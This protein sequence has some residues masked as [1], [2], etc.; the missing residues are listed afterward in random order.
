MDQTRRMGQH[1]ERAYL[2]NAPRFS[3]YRNGRD[4]YPSN[5]LDRTLKDGPAYLFGAAL[6]RSGTD[7]PTSLRMPK[8]DGLPLY[9]SGTHIPQSAFHIPHFIYPG[10]G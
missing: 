8:S 4:G 9:N 2:P 7:R 10:N 3:P 5:D 1:N 6:R